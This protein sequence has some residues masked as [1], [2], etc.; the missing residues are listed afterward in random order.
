M[1]Y[2]FLPDVARPAVTV[3]ML[4]F[5]LREGALSL[6]LIERGLPPFRGRLALPG[7][8][9]HVGAGGA[10]GEALDDAAARELREETGLGR[11]RVTLA[12]LGAFGRPGRDPRGRTI[13]VAYFALV[14]PE[15]ARGVRAG[16]DAAGA[17]WLRVSDV[18]HDAL[19]FDHGRIVV[20]ALARLRHDVDRAGA[21]L[22][23][24]PATFTAREL[25][26]VHE[27]IHGR[28]LDA[29]NFDR[30]LRR[31]I[32]DGLIEPVTERRPTGRRPAR[33]FRAASTVSGE[34]ARARS[35]ARPGRSGRPA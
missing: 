20:E 18:D 31:L 24:V 3:D 34:P 26:E 22:A 9:L 35:S 10:G 6:L 14:R 21:A 11:E 12:Q 5:T 29:A 32:D 8:F 7:G 19:A 33:L 28:R 25:R 23:L 30:R 27:T 1:P 2:T 17:R 4:V 15:A 13:T 16:S